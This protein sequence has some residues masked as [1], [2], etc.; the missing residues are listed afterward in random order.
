MSFPICD[1]I[2][3]LIKKNLLD[4]D[5][6]LN[7]RIDGVGSIRFDLTEEG[8]M[9]STKKTISVVDINGRSYTITVEENINEHQV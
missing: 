5:R 6:K 8:V 1:Y 9:R 4:W 7:Q 3:H 2:S